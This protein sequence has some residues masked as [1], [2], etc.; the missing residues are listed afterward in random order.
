MLAQ[1]N[2]ACDFKVPFHV[3]LCEQ[4]QCK[5]AFKGMSVAELCKLD[6][7]TLLERVPAAGHRKR[8]VLA[9]QALSAAQPAVSVEEKP[10]YNS[11]SSLYIDSTIVTPCT[12]EIIFCVSIVIHDRVEEGEKA[13]K[14]RLAPPYETVRSAQSKTQD[15]VALV[16]S[17]LMPSEAIFVH[18]SVSRALPLCWIGSRSIRQC[19]I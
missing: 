14:V 9:L 10:K 16:H 2:A 18:A 15:A 12:D 6:N 8:I 11:T 19:P 5:P 4:P 13:N 7:A 3:P 17:L 1:Q